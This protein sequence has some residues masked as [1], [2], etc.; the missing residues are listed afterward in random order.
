ML[1]RLLIAIFLTLVKK[2]TELQF[3]VDQPHHETSVLSS[4]QPFQRVAADA[5]D[6]NTSPPSTSSD[7]PMPSIQ[8]TQKQITH[9]TLLQ[10]IV[11]I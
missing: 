4:F 11:Q 6:A 9:G 10:D 3:F 7:Q 2:I 5:I 1:H 8:I